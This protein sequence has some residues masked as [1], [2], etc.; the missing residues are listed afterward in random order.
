[1]D[2]G[3]ILLILGLAA[4]FLGFLM[5]NAICSTVGVSIAIVGAV[6]FFTS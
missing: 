5:D 6:L 1:M 2:P 3:P 4:L